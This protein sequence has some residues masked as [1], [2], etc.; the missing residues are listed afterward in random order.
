MMFDTGSANI[1][2]PSA[3]CIND[4]CQKHAKY[5]SEESHGYEATD[6]HFFIKYGTGRVEGYQS[7][8]TVT[9]SIIFISQELRRFSEFY[10]DI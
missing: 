2:V 8:D 5:V 6:E 4:A 9:V 1:W 10:F 3:K 7:Y